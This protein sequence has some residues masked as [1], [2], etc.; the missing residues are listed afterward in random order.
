MV[1]FIGLSRAGLRVGLDPCGSLPT[2]LILWFVIL[3]TEEPVLSEILQEMK[4]NLFLDSFRRTQIL[5]LSTSCLSPFRQLHQ[6]PWIFEMEMNRA[7]ELWIC[8]SVLNKNLSLIQQD[9]T[10]VAWARQQ[11]KLWSCHVFAASQFLWHKNCKNSA[12][13]GSDKYQQFNCFL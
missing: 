5:N 12:F 8:H 7:K 1:E 13:L 4:I 2:Q 11:T 10:L 9:V 6:K 3:W